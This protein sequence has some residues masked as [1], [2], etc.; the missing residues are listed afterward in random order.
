LQSAGFFLVL[1][2]TGRMRALGRTVVLVGGGVAMGRIAALAISGL[3]WLVHGA[4]EP[5]GVD[6]GLPVTHVNWVSCEGRWWRMV[7]AAS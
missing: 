6:R 7:V 5:L 3:L 1:V 4:D 2:F